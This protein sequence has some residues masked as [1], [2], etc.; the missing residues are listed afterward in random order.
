MKKS[1]GILFAA[2]Q[3]QG[4]ADPMKSILQMSVLAVGTIAAATA[5]V[6]CEGPPSG[7]VAGTSLIE[8]IVQDLSGDT[9][10]RS[11]LRSLIPPRMCP[12]H[13]DVRPADVE[14]AAAS[15]LVII[16]DWQQNMAAVTGLLQAAHVP[17]ERVKVLQV[18]GHWMTP[19]AYQQAIGA[20]GQMLSEADPANAAV[21]LGR[22][23]KR[24]HEIGT[25]GEQLGSSL[26]AAGISGVR[27]VCNDKQAEF[28]RWAGFDVVAEF[29]RPEDMSVADVEDLLRKTR[30][31]GAALIVDNLQ[32]GSTQASSAVARDAGIIHVVLSNFPGGFENTE[33]WEEAVGKNVD[34]LLEAARRARGRDG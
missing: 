21:Y 13:F 26:A 10:D 24:Q 27:V 28:V 25:L 12:G 23:S 33:T 11:E 9:I 17:D 3:D 8:G 29:G 15:R 22:V 18:I 19:P 31:T 2:L 5:L 4:R 20:V 6:S 1:Q 32:S 34:L 30:E 14:A 16:H 7:V